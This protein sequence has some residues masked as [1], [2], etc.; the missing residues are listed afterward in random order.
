MC[1]RQQL[2]ASPKYDI[3]MDGTVHGLI[4][5]GVDGHDVGEYTAV[6]RRK[7]S[8]AKLTVEG[9]VSYH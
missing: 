7:T 8:K 3:V 1:G 2:S 9:K 4:L 5:H 6:A